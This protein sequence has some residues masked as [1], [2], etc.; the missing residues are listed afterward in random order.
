MFASPFAAVPGF[1][2]ALTTFDAATAGGMPLYGTESPTNPLHASPLLAATNG[3]NPIAL[4][5][6]VCL[7]CMC[8]CDV[9]EGMMAPPP[10]SPQQLSCVTVQGCRPFVVYTPVF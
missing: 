8:L 2:T 4:I 6:Y 3:S 1:G 9:G 5:Y 10:V 7:A